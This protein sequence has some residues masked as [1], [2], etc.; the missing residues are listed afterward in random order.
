MIELLELWNLYWREERPR[1]GK[2]R[3]RCFFKRLRPPDELH[4]NQW[5]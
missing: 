5:F 2:N 1:E 4:K 3:N